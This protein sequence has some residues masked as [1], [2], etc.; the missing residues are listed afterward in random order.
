MSQLGE[1]VRAGELPRPD[2]APDPL[3]RI[4]GLRKS[5]GALEVLC[6]IS[7]EVARGEVLALIGP[8]GSGKTTLLRCVNLLERPTGGEVWIDRSRIGQ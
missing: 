7:L 4:L 1:K 6:G 8:S 3:V 2:A 5:F